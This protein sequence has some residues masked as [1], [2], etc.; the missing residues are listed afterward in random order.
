MV[1]LYVAT[2]DPRY[3]A[4]YEE[5]LAIRAGTAP[6]PRGYDS[7][8]WDRVLAEGKGFVEYGPPESLVDADAGGATSRRAEFDAL[9]ASLRASN[10]LAAA[11]ARGDGARRAAHPPG[12]RRRYFAD[13]HPDYQRLVDD[14]YLAEKGVIMDAID[15]FIALVDERTLSDVEGVRADNRRL[16]AAQIAILGLIVLVGV[17]A[18]VVL[19]RVALRRSAS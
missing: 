15:H 1:R 13:V 10:D 19:T 11:R 2:G 17:A 14:A 16:F 8:F 9:N 7:S 5:I 4:Y 6:R 3:R 12:R 18:M